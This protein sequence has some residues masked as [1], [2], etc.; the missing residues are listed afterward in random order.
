MSK[1]T[2]LNKVSNTRQAFLLSFF[3]PQKEYEEVAVNGFVLVK[4]INGITG[5]PIVAIYTKQ[6]FLNYKEFSRLQSWKN[7]KPQR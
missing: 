4:Q 2:A 1:K 5:E 3:T 6:K 7:K